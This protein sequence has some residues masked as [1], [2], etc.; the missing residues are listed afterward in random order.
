ME[1]YHDN[2]VYFEPTSHSYLLDG[3]V[4]LQGVTELMHKHNLGADY[5]NTPKAKLEQAAAE[6]TA[7]HKEIQEYEKGE[8]FFASEL[9]DEYKKLNLKFVEAEYPITDYEIIASAIDCVYEGSA[10]NKVKLV[11]IK[12]TL[13][14]HRRPLE[15]QLGIYKVYFEKMNPSLE[16]EEC[17]C[18]WIDKKARKINAFQHVNP[19]TEDEVKALLDAERNGEIYIDTNDIPDLGEVLAPEEADELVANAGKIAELE[20]TLK[21]LK[22]ASEQ[23][24][25][26]LLE[27]MVEHNLTEISCPGGVFKLKAAYSTTRVDSKALKSLYPA[28]Y[29]KVAKESEVKASITYKSLQ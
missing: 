23:I 22:E 18:L 2:R 19:V 13:K 9:I 4:L 3:D 11:D 7:I 5:S 21:I 20:N 17:L 29:T 27:Y 25:E 14:Y 1:L 24:R 26:K 15:W 12:T 10:P 6:G 28:V 16:V 8:S